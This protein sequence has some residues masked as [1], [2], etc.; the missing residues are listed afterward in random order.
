MASRVSTCSSRRFALFCPNM[1]DW[2]K[3]YS[4][5]ASACPSTEM[6]GSGHLRTTTLINTPAPHA[7]MT[8]SLAQP[9]SPVVLASHRRRHH[10]LDR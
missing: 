2:N 8:L 5:P 9:F 7:T 1:V 4:E 6:T 3:S 10:E